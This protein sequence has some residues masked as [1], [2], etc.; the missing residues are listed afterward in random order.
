MA[1]ALSAAAVVA[2][3]AARFSFTTATSASITRS[4][5]ASVTETLLVVNTPDGRFAYVTSPDAKA[6]TVVDARVRVTTPC[7]PA[8]SKTW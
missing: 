1:P 4:I 8:R 7:A 5:V 2:D 3:W 6:L